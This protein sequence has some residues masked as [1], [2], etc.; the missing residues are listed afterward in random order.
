MLKICISSS[1]KTAIIILNEIFALLL[2]VVLIL[3]SNYG[4]NSGSWDD[5][6]THRT[7]E[8][9]EYFQT[10][11]VNQT[12][13]AIRAAVR[14]ARFEEDGVYDPKRFVNIA[15]YAQKGVITG[16]YDSEGL[17]YRL[18]DLL[19]WAQKGWD[20][21]TVEIDSQGYL[22]FHGKNEGEASAFEEDLE[23]YFLGS[24]AEWNAYYQYYY[25]VS[26]EAEVD[27]KEN[28]TKQILNEVYNRKIIEI[29]FPMPQKLGLIWIPYMGR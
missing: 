10:Q 1:V 7:F 24:N 26:D 19:N 18:G 11:S 14:A 27:S 22:T 12:T 25:N 5:L 29:L 6:L 23:K 17:Y 28:Y 2:I 20:Y 9:S 4:V 8:Q 21:S 15:D 16:K 3:T 13:R